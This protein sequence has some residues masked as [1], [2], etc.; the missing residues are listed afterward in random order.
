MKNKIVIG[1]IALI[2]ILTGVITFYRT[3]NM[4]EL[5]TG[6]KRYRKDGKPIIG[7]ETTGSLFDPNVIKDYDG[8]YRMYVSWRNKGAIAVC[9][10]EDGI[11]WSDLQIVLEQKPSSGWENEVNRATVIMKDNQYYMWYT[12][13]SKKISRIGYAVSKDGYTWE[14][15]DNPVLV[16]EYDFEGMSVM[17]P[18]VMYDE[19]IYKMYYASGETYEPDVIAYATSEDGIHWNK[20]NQNPIFAKSNNKR[21][22]DNFKIGGCEVMKNDN[23]EY[24]MF[25]IGYTDIDTARIFVASSKDGINWTRYRKPIVSPSRWKFD[26]EATYKPSVIYDNANNRYLLYYNGRKGA[27]EYIGLYYKNMN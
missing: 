13:Q 26:S 20:Y 17:N 8:L 27:N 7:D 6:W 11:N 18:Y 5:A 22:L 15:N 16:P 1:I 21:D 3:D 12:G 2:I 4:Y 9:T 10:S 14:R 19:G 25:Y 24:T 23:G